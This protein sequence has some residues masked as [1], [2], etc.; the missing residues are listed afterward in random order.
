MTAKVEKRRAFEDTRRGI[1]KASDQVAASV[2]QMIE[3]F[4]KFVQRL[5]NDGTESTSV[6]VVMEAIQACGISPT[7]LPPSRNKTKVQKLR[8]RL[9][10]QYSSDNATNGVDA[11]EDGGED[12]NGDDQRL[13]QSSDQ[14]GLENELDTADGGSSQ[15]SRS[16]S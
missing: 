6:N 11:T 16:D 7:P 15:H 8:Q 4:T 13:E 10:E 9:L 5:V 12:E 14:G 3:T 2:E 1:E